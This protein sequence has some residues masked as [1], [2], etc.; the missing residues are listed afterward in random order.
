MPLGRSELQKMFDQRRPDGEG[1]Q[2]P[3]S[4]G[5]QKRNI[6]DPDTGTELGQRLLGRL[7][8]IDQVMPGCG[9]WA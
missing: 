7:N 5:R 6:G 8:K 4:P 9:H 1:K 3:I 2:G